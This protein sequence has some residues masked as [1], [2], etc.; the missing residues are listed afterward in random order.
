MGAVCDDGSAIFYRIPEVE[1]LKKIQVNNK[2]GLWKICFSYNNKYFCCT[3]KDTQ[4]YIYNLADFS[5]FKVLQGHD[6]F[7][8]AAEFN[9]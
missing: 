8:C 3:G 5:L 2:Q 4:V 6:N 7:V 9:K 1:F